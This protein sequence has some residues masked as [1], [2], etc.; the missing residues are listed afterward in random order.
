MSIVS[1][2]LWRGTRG[3]SLEENEVGGVREAGKEEEGSRI[4][5]VVGDVGEAGFPR[6]WEM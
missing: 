5:K 1:F 3:G 2:K 6:W 4:P